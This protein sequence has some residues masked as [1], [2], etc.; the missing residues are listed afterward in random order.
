M[1][2]RINF[3]P[4]QYFGANATAMLYNRAAVS[5][6]GFSMP[7]GTSLN[8]SIPSYSSGLKNNAINSGP[9]KTG[10]KDCKT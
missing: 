4:M 6:S 2:G 9:Q 1:I 10:D 5:A 7:S 3:N 8:Q